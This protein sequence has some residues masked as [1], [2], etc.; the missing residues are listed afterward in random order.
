MF[1]LGGYLA[2]RY[3]P[4]IIIVNMKLF[5]IS[6]DVKTGHDYNSL[7]DALDRLHAVRVLQSV[8]ALKANTTVQALYNYLLPHLKQGDRL[9]VIDSANSQWTP[10][11]LENPNHL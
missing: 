9:L 6:Y 8:L 7:Y 1:E 4:V 2:W 10:T 11:A 5:Y 3:P